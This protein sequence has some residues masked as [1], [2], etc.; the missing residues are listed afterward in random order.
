MNKAPLPLALVA[1]CAIALEA[2]DD[3]ID[4]GVSCDQKAGLMTPWCMDIDNAALAWCSDVSHHGEA[5]CRAG[6]WH[7]PK[8]TLLQLKCKC[9]GGNFPCTCGPNG[10][11]CP[12][13][14]A[15]PID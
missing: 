5:V 4:S 13:R 15:G 12:P 7:C 6:T 10:W 1:L 8:G 2:C 14:D 9:I 11:V 3:T